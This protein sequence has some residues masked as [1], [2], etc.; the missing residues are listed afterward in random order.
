MLILWIKRQYVLNF[1]GKSL[2]W[3]ALDKLLQCDAEGIFIIDSFAARPPLGRK[4]LNIINVDPPPSTI[5]PN[6]RGDQ[7]III[8]YLRG[9]VILEQR[10]HS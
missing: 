9:I 5:Y 4:I 10:P 6:V 1:L 2:Y 8:L 7:Q 3:R